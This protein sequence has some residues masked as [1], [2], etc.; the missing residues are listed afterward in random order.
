MKKLS[1]LLATTLILLTSCKE[2]VNT[3]KELKADFIFKNAKVYT[4]NS[5]NPWAES[6]AV[7]G[8][9]IVYVGNEE[10]LESLYGP[11]TQELDVNGK[12][13]LPGFIDSHAHPLLTAM[14]AS[15]YM[16]EPTADVS[17]LLSEMEEYIKNNPD[18]EVIFGFGGFFQG[19]FDLNKEMLDKLDAN[20]PIIMIE[21]G[22]HGGW[23]NSKVFE[24]LGIDETFPD[25][26]PG[27]S[28]YERDKDGRPTGVIVEIAAF[29]YI[30]DNLNIIQAE[31]LKPSM[32]GVAEM[33][34]ELGYTSIYD[35]GVFAPLDEDIYPIIS[36]LAK[37]GGMNLRIDASYAVKSMDKLKDAVPTLNEYQKF[38]HGIFRINT[39][40]SYVDGTMESRSAAMDEDYLDTPG[41]K[42]TLALSGD[43]FLATLIDLAKNDYNIHLH[44]MGPRSIHEVLT[45]GAKV[46]EAGYNDVT[47]TN[48]HT[49]LVR[50]EDMDMFKKYNIIPNTSALWHLYTGEHYIPSLGEER[51]KKLFRYESLAK[52]GVG[53]T[54]GTDY[55]AAEGG[56]LGANPLL[57]IECAV[58]RQQPA[59]LGADERI[60]PPIDERLSVAHAVEAF[61]INGAK[62]MRLDKSVGSLEIG[63]KADLIIL[64]ENIFDVQ[65]NQ[66]GNSEV[67][68][69]LFNGQIVHDAIFQNENVDSFEDLT[70][71]IDLCDE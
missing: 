15:G 62:Q 48:G 47:I 20:R 28:F 26:M 5:E 11:D 9:S 69:T 61:T 14:L 36:E 30:L 25:P 35:A 7:S 55:P 42:G 70:L 50:D 66:I 16:A 8:D 27:Y 3:N 44:A 51:W 49:Q 45:A 24:M 18:E 37:E 57:Q 2:S 71:N 19:Q 17:T 4:V 31:R 39:F 43:E 6:I 40:K 56:A 65:P 67:I 12:L 21:S 32:Q 54:I 22:G 34:N 58:T 59:V 38:N 33:M 60:Q 63:K 41:N 46:R 29:V 53:V 68:F 10:G 1:L 13:I 64:S 52:D 23:A